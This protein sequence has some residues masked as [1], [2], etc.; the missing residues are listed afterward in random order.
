MSK[1]FYHGLGV[2]YFYDGT[3]TTVLEV[4]KTGGLKCKRLL[5]KRNSGYNGL[6]YISICKKYTEEEYDCYGSTGFYKF[7]QD[8]FCFIIS[9]DIEAIK[10]ETIPKSYWYFPDIVE[11]M[12]YHPENRYSDMFDEWQVKGEIPL[13]YIVGIGVPIRWLESIDW[14]IHKN[15]LQELKSIVDIA[16]SLG[17][18]I[19]DST[20][21]GFIEEYELEKRKTGGKVYQISLDS[22]L[23]EDSYE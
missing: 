5:G 21:K 9:D 7:V 14:R 8:S 23:K 20:K 11:K 10:T 2:P 15:A 1:Y 22:I 12:K 17:L 3:I 19:V 18:D 4:F 13:S 16:Q 6:D